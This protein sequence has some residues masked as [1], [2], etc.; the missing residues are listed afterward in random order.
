[1][2]IEAL[3]LGGLPAALGA[4]WAA[5][6]RARVA[7]TRVLDRQAAS[8]AVTSNQ[9][10]DEHAKLLEEL[11]HSDAARA[12]AEREQDT[13]AQQLRQQQAENDAL[14]GALE[15]A[16]TRAGEAD[17]LRSAALTQK[18]DVL[19]HL[20]LLAGEA[21]AL[22]DVAITF[23][24]WHQEMD[25]LMA[26]NREMHRQNDEF[27]AIVEHIVIVSLNAAIEAARAGE[28][29]RTFA[30]VADEVRTL[31]TRSKALSKDYRTSLYKNDMTTTATFQEIQADGKMIVSA[32]G[33]LEALIARLRSQVDAPA[34]GGSAR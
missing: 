13:L 10:R 18:S 27:G 2:A 14:R 31:A 32:I 16:A 11:A 19:R 9:Q 26:Q 33:G 28:S 1:M 5:G 20:D 22:R 34:N 4:W 30:V 29:G 25:S 12:A 21:G 6:Y 15:L 24:H 3:L 17:E 7:V 23:E 8:H